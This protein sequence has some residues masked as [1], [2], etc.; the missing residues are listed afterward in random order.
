MTASLPSLRILRFILSLLRWGT[1]LGIV[2]ITV[3]TVIL[4]PFSGKNVSFDLIGFASG[5]EVENWSAATR[6]GVPATLKMDE[7]VRVRLSV[8]GEEPWPIRIWLVV[9]SCV[10]V[11][12]ALLLFLFLLK[13]FRSILDTVE[14]GDPFVPENVGRIRRIGLLVILGAFFHPLSMGCFSALTDALFVVEGIDLSVRFSLNV[15]AFVAGL[16]LLV[17][18][19]IF[20]YGTT[21]REE[22][23]LTI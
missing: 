1:L 5:F 11:V 4:G 17:L 9:G 23:S 19:E 6:D 10:W 8:S 3:V 21:M 2:A 12:G 15:S 22:Q 7:P 20:R 13:Q 18:S 16:S 14:A